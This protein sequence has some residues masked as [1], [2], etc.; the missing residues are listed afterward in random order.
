MLSFDL[1]LLFSYSLCSRFHSLPSSIRDIGARIEEK[2]EEG[3]FEIEQDVEISNK[4]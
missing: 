4:I 2:E 3:V 1:F